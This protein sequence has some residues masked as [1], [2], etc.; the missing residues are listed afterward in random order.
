[1]RPLRLDRIVERNVRLVRGVGE[2]REVRLGR[3]RLHRR[4]EIAGVAGME[5]GAVERLVDQ[6]GARAELVG[7][8]ELIQLIE[9]NARS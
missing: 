8:D 7:V 6:G 9:A 5:G 2:Q 1:M 4:R 3:L